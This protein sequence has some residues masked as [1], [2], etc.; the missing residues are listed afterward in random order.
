MQKRPDSA[1][2]R[3]IIDKRCR[4]LHKMAGDLLMKLQPVFHRPFSDPSIFDPG[5]IFKLLI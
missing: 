2:V 1:M 5:A 3:F 4:S